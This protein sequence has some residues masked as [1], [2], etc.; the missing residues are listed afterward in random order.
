MNR[1]TVARW[2]SIL[3]YAI[4]GTAIS[5]VASLFVTP[6]IVVTNAFGRISF[7]LFFGVMA[8]ILGT[9]LALF[10]RTPL[11]FR[12]LRYI[13]RYPPIWISAFVG[14]VLCWRIMPTRAYPF[15]F[16]ESMLWGSLLVGIS[17]AWSW[18]VNGLE[19]SIIHWPKRKTQPAPQNPRGSSD[20]LN[21][22]EDLNDW[23][24]R[25]EPI[26]SASRDS[27]SM[28][29]IAGRIAAI[30]AQSP[31]KQKQTTVGLLGNFG[32]GKTSTVNMVEERVRIDRLQPNVLF[33]R[34]SCW[35]FDDSRGALKHVLSGII[36]TLSPVVDCT[37][38]R[39]LPTEYLEALSDRKGWGSILLG[40]LG[41]ESDP[42]VQLK[43]LEPILKATGLR[44]CL[45]VEDIDRGPSPTFD[46]SH[47]LAMLNR[48]REV[49][50]VSFILTTSIE[51][52]NQI[53]FTKL[54]RN[55]AE[56]KARRS[57][58]ADKG[59]REHR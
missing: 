34:A 20:T 25:E 14:T 57:S 37:S 30:I 6:K 2:F 55:F 4:S 8:V 32:S 36:E 33:A 38:V 56:H 28:Q 35:G 26:E 39:A 12:G 44:L 43:R 52:R 42:S 46:P 27:F 58:M 13:S 5:V 22:W 15:G 23:S 47:V 45:V 7:E 9:I 17:L 40:L 24:D 1:F 10:R 59:D 16:R 49:A 29:G 50:N 51:S 31:E 41:R 48:I 54:S 11:S 19:S 18:I 3:I 21:S 53:D